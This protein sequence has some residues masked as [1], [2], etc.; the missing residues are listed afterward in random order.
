MACYHI[1]EKF[2]SMRSLPALKRCYKSRKTAETV[3]RRGATGDRA[4]YYL[5]P[6]RQLS[7]VSCYDVDHCECAGWPAGHNTAIIAPKPRKALI[8]CEKCKKGRRNAFE[9]LDP[10]TETPILLCQRCGERAALAYLLKG[11]S[12]PVRRIHA[13]DPSMSMVALQP[14]EE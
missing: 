2:A 14:D 6:G 9:F 8:M 1:V 3:R 4:D 10:K 7:V 11:Q 5:D 12:P 13:D